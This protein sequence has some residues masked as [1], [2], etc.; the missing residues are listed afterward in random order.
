MIDVLHS[1]RFCD[2]SPYEVYAT[3]LDE[4]FYLASI[5]TFYRILQQAS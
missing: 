3:L 2:Q 5:R 1:E 4:G